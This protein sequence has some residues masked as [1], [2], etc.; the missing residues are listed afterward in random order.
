MWK[1]RTLAKKG[2]D[3]R[4]ATD[5]RHI[6]IADTHFNKGS[7]REKIGPYKGPLLLTSRALQGPP[8]PGPSSTRALRNQQKRV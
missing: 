8:A 1:Y 3:R 4:S 7:D 2:S 6:I 5:H